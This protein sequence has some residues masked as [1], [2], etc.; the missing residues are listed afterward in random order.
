MKRI[1]CLVFAIMLAISLAVPALGA[2]G[3]TDV[4]STAM[5]T[6][7][8][9][10]Q[11]TMTAVIVIDS[12]TDDLVFPL[13]LNASRITLN[14]SKRVSTRSNG[15]VLEVNLS[16]YYGGV[17]SYPLTLTYEL[18]GCV[19]ETETGLQLRIPLLSGF[20]SPVQDMEFSVSL[21]GTNYQ[22]PAFSSGY[23]Q[24]NIEKDLQFS[25]SG[26]SITGKTTKEL[27]DHETLDLLLPVSEEMFPQKHI[28]PPSLTFCTTATWVCLGLAFLYWLIFLR[29]LPPLYMK[30]P[31]GPE[32]G[33]AGEIGSVLCGNGADLT[34][35]VFSWAQMGYLTIDAMSQRIILYKQMEMGNERG[36]FE[37]K[38]FQM[39]FRNRDSVDTNSLHYVSLSKQLAANRPRLEVF[40]HPKSGNP[41]FF[42]YFTAGI[43]VFTG[44]SIGIHTASGGVLQWFWAV[45]LAILAGLSGMR[46][47]R[48]A[49]GLYLRRKYYWKQSAILSGLW[50]I[51]SLCIGQFSLGLAL[52]FS[53]LVGGFFLS[54]GGRRTQEGKYAMSEILGL[55]RYLRTIRKNDLQRITAQQPDFFHTQAPYAFALGVQRGF[56]RRMGQQKISSCPYITLPF[57]KPM[58]AA[59][60]CQKMEAIIA[61]MEHRERNLILEKVSKKLPKM[62]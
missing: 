26:N 35:M 53:Q 50:L 29:C 9:T 49:E 3:L 27:K 40:F 1:V 60:W 30:T 38:Y 28:K 24:S 21:P 57:D 17:G 16:R 59:Q 42:R 5:V 31:N 7:D 51:L 23:H 61:F 11:I 37:R 43:A 19:E 10:C 56:A 15:D 34:M 2:T 54:F 36:P 25:F 6:N 14:G 44:M 18:R 52:V 58:T 32:G 20:S 4:S 12:P 22:K 39:L 45:I 41:R 55:R 8:G 33:T 13:P 62:K 48:M 47:Q 46:M